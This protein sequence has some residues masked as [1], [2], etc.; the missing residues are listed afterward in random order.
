MAATDYTWGTGRRKSAVVRVRVRPGTGTFVVN[1]REMKQY[2]P[3]AEWQ[4]AAT[5][6]LKLLGKEED[7]DVIATCRG[8]GPTGQAEALAM[9]LAR[10]LKEINPNDYLALREAGFM[11]RDQRMKERKKYGLAGARRA[12]QFSKR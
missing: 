11:T 4:R 2:F 10:A 6:P 1:N 8:G 3:S 9:G 7:Y 5:G 12:F